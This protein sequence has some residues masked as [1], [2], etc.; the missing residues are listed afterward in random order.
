MNDISI[1][2]YQP[3]YQPDFKRLNIAWISESFTVEEHDLEQ[4]DHPETY[5]LP[6]GGQ[7]LLAKQGDE[8]VGTAAM[9]PTGEGTYELAKMSVASALRG[10]GVGKL[11]A[12]G[13]I[14]YA[15]E[16][17]ATLI[18]LES[19]R[20]AVAAIELY[21]R[22]GFVEVPLRPSPYTRADICM[23]MRL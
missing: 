15:R 5:I 10:Q 22:V 17:G 3:Q 9:V 4:L 14:A 21:K 18:W 12:L 7:I 11:L 8:I 13:A 2:Y 1:I 23:E 20:K 6:N 16:V 19:N